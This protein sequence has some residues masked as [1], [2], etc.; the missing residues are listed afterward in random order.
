MGEARDQ[1]TT[2]KAKI[3]VLESMG[4]ELYAH[5]PID[6]DQAIES[7]ELAELAEDAGAGEV[8]SSG[9]EG[10]IV[11]R[12]DPESKAAEGR[13]A[14]AVGE[15]RADPPLRPGGRPGTHFRRRRLERRA[16]GH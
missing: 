2:F 6:T 11:A 8:P 12:L 5:F 15:R 1:G 14:R 7:Q 4:S 16:Q 10:R 3:E 13:G 9:E